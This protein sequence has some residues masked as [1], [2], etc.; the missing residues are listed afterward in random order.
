MI[1][2]LDAARK[3]LNALA[4][5]SSP[6]GDILSVAVTTSRLDDWRQ[7]V[8]AYINS[9]FT[10][11]TKKRALK[12]ESKRRLQAGLDYVMDLV[13]YDIAS[14]T[15]G[16]MAFSDGGSAVSEGIELPLRLTNSLTIEPW[17]YVRPLAN[18]LYLLE[19]FVLAEISRD[20]SSL[21][22]VD[23]W[24][25]TSENDLTGPWLRSSDRDTG[26]VSIKKYYAA[27]RHDGLVEQ[28]HKEVA[29]SLAKLFDLSGARRVVV[30]A[31]HDIAAAF[32]RVLPAA[33]AGSV[34]AE[35]SLDTTASVGQRVAVARRAVEQA[36]H[37]RA[38]SL[39][40]RLKEGLGPGGHGAAGFDDVAGAIRLGQVDTL[41]VD[42]DHRA[43]GWRCKS[44]LWVGL[45]AA[46]GCPVCGGEIVSVEDAL[47][48]L[49]RLTILQHG[50]VEVGEDVAGLEELGGVAG[51]L[52]YA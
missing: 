27:A 40:E 26:E 34:I 21:Y 24:G 17:P 51:L 29:S 11:L 52:R 6:Q 7:T 8:P 32:R 42:R 28:H 16:L 44:C 18:A 48:E 47:G 20:D 38:V 43:Q 45:S 19:P 9:E 13:K 41:L 30:C 46:E 4:A 35:I 10:R 14:T 15:Q 25:V 2:S 33:L 3:S 49:V 39:L 31:Q 22:V 50:Q 12:G 5:S 36:R 37:D 1:D 23:E